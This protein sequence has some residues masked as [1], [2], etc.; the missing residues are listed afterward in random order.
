MKT[1]RSLPKLALELERQR[2]SKKDYLAP[3]GLLEMVPPSSSKESTSPAEHISVRGV[4]DF[5][6]NDHAHSQ[7]ASRL[8]IPMPYYKRMRK[9]APELLS[10]N[11]NH[12][13]QTKPEKRMVR[14]MDGNIRAFLSDRYRPLDNADLADAVLPTL[15]EADAEVISC[16]VTERRLYIKAII[17]GQ[18]I[19]IGPP[20]GWEWGKGHD[21]IDIVQ[22]GIVISNSEIGSGSMAIRPAVHTVKCT[23]LAVWSDASLRKYHIGSALGSTEGEV[24][25]YITDE[26]RKLADAAVWSEVRDLT[27][28]ALV[29]EAFKDICNSIR[30]ARYDRIESGPQKV[31][32]IVSERFLLTQNEGDSVLEHL[33]RDGDLT[34]YGLYNAVTR[35]ASDA[36][37]YDRASEIEIAG[38]DIIELKPEDWR[39]ITARAA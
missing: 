13:F 7:I 35:T 14:T 3:T 4:G 15:I 38:G 5:G 11:V 31:V 12:W 32:E 19:E 26:T 16:E 28:A 33:I 36:A 24:H 17:P 27:K 8:G 10:R 9:D 6:V 34:R 18:E 1:G 2:E 29:G 39:E 20:E 25:K 23:N 21:Q 22:P 30:A 37:S